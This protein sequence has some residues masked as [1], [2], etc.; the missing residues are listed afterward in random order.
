MLDERHRR[1]VYSS[2]ARHMQT[3]ARFSVCCDHAECRPV[4]HA[5]IPISG[6]RSSIIAMAASFHESSASARISHGG[7]WGPSL[8]STHSVFQ[9]FESAK[10]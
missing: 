1:V 2:T 5:N 4:T 6:V 7:G 10:L 9:I 3:Q 8:C